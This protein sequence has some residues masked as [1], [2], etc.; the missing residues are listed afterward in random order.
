MTNKDYSCAVFRRLYADWFW[1]PT[2]PTGPILCGNKNAQGQTCGCR[3]DDKGIHYMICQAGGGV[4]RRHDAVVRVLASLIHDITR[5]RV[6][7][8]R[9]SATL[10]RMVNGVNQEGQMDIIVMTLDGSVQYID[11]AI[12]SPVIANQTHIANAA[13]RDGYAARR[14]ENY[15]KSRYPVAGL[16]PF[17]IELG[18]RPGNIARKFVSALFDEDDPSKPTGVARVWST[19]SSVLNS[20]IAAQMGK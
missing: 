2:P 3:V 11:V 10:D 15:K 9:R 8:E 1:L 17:V 4:M 12:V 20:A 13:V 14:A 16:V 18:G 7:V 5:A 6:V 19:I